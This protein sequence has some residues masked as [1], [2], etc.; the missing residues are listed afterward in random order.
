[1]KLNKI[2]A[3]VLFLL[4]VQSCTTTKLIE[5]GATAYEEGNYKAALA[6]WEQAINENEQKGK[7]VDS[8]IYYKAGMSAWKLNQSEKT[9]S[10][11][12]SAD[13]SGYSSPALYL[14]LSGMYKN[15][16]NLSLE[17]D[18]LEKY[19]ESYPEAADI[20]SVNIRLFETYVESEQ[21]N[22]AN[23]LWTDL[24]EKAKLELEMQKGFFKVTTAL[25]NDA[26]NDKL[27]RLILEKEPNNLAALEWNAIKYFEKADD[28]YIKVMKAYDEKRSIENYNKLLKAWDKIWP[29]FEKSRDYFKK[30]YKLNPKPHYATYLGHIYKRMD[31]EQ[32][33][34]YWYKKAE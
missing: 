21:W 16:D 15:I 30:L 29:D 25:E 14:I 20:D 34:T 1:M 31:K 33:S 22:K 19:N 2:I 17:I 7:T 13:E 32:K 12:K 18:A 26:V 5:D 4:V 10:Y 24:T 11:L 23:K 27:A 6:K 28:L 3:G 9:R 8:A